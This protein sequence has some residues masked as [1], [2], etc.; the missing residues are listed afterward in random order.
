[1]KCAAFDVPVPIPPGL[2]DQLVEMAGEEAD[3]DYHVNTRGIYDPRCARPLLVGCRE[4]VEEFAGVP[5]VLANAYFRVYE[6]GAHLGEHVDRP[7]LDWTVSIMLRIDAPPW[8]IEVKNERGEWEELHGDAVV[9]R[10]AEVL[11]RRSVPYPGNEACVLMLHYR[12]TT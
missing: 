6:R 10:A 5:L 8:P 7:G 3:N 1:M 9:M 2:V 4:A 12:E 11:H